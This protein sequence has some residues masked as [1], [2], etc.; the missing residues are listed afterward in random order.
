MDLEESTNRS[1]SQEEHTYKEGS[2]VKHTPD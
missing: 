2:R 1:N